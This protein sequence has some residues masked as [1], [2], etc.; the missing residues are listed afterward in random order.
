M[1]L[2]LEEIVHR[3]KAQGNFFLLNKEE[4]RGRGHLI[5]PY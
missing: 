3:Q 1:T 5:R 4:S 2:Q